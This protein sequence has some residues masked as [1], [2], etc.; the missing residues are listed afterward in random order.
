MMT[1]VAE[2]VTAKLVKFLHPRFSTCTKCGEGVWM[3]TSQYRHSREWGGVTAL[4]TCSGRW[5]EREGGGLHWREPCR[6][7]VT[8]SATCSGRRREREGGGLHWRESCSEGRGGRAWSRGKGGGT[9]CVP[10]YALTHTWWWACGHK[11]ISVPSASVGDRVV[12]IHAAP[13]ALRLSYVCMRT[14]WVKG[15]ARLNRHRPRRQSQA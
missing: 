1:E 3:L 9:Q 2:M 6:G 5:R 10:V 8:A 12:D 15:G 11:G 14:S 7:G 13:S 4:A